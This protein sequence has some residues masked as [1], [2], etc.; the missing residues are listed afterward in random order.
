VLIDPS[1]ETKSDYTN[2]VKALKDSLT[3]F[4]TGTFA[5]WYPVIERKRNDS[6]EQALKASG[7]KNIQ[8]FE[9]GLV[10][11][12]AAPG[13]TAS[14]L[15]VINPPFTLMA[16]MRVALPWLAEVLGTAGAGHYR[17]E[18]LAAE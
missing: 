6:L 5:L 11:D 2:V 17:A 8:L 13:M 16:E 1:Y 3:R 10:A 7:I 18:Q 15:L 12:H 14:G 4:A 9:L